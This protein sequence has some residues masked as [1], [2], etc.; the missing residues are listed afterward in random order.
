MINSLVTLA[1]LWPSYIVRKLAS[2]P[3][4]ALIGLYKAIQAPY[5]VLLA[6]VV[7][8]KLL[9]VKEQSKGMWLTV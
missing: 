5:Q 1:N 6:L 7:A 9:I 3:Y 2:S 8:T 4:L